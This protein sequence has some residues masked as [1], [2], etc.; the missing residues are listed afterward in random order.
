MKKALKITGWTLLSLVVVVLIVVCVAVYVVFTPER[1]TP[2]VR[3]YVPQFVTCETSLD[4]A[5]LT[6]FSTFPEFG[7]RLRNV[8]LKNPMCGAPSDTLANIDNL[9]A[10]IDV[11]QFLA[12]DA[13]VVK[14]VML[15]G[16][17]VNLY[18]DSLGRT[19]YDIVVASD[20]EQDTTATDLPFDLLDIH[21]VQIAN[22]RVL[23]TD[24]QNRMR[25]SIDD[26]QA[27]IS[28]NYAETDVM[29]DVSLQL[30]QVLFATD[31]TTRIEVQVP[32]VALRTKAALAD[33]DA[34]ASI[35]L[36]LNSVNCAIGGD[37]LLTQADI[38]AT[39]PLTA[40]LDTLS[41][42]LHEAELALAGHKI[43][44]DGWAQMRDTN[45]V[46]NVDFATDG[47]WQI[48]KVVSLIP[49]SYADL[50]DGIDVEGTIGLSGCVLGVYNSDTLPQITANVDLRNAKVVID[51]LPYKLYDVGAKAT[52]HLDLN[53]GAMSDA[54]ITQLTAKTGTC[55]VQAAGR[56]TDLL[57]AL[58]CNLHLTADVNLPE[59]SPLLPADLNVALVGRTKADVQTK[60][61]LADVLALNLDKIVAQGTL[62]FS[63]LDVVYNDSIFVE[64]PALTLNVSLPSPGKNRS[65]QEM[66]QAQITSPDLRIEMLG[67]LDAALTDATLTVATSNVLDTT[68]MLSATCEFAMQHLLAHMDTISA[69][70]VAPKG[71]ITLSPSRRNA[72][73]PRL[74]CSYSSEMLSANMGSAFNAKTKHIDISASTTY[75][76]TQENLYLKWNP[77]LKIDFNDGCFRMAGID[78]EIRI[79][80]IKFAFT[81]RK[82]TI[83]DSRIIID[84]SDFSLTGEARNIRK[85]M[86]HNGLLEGEFDFVSEQTDINQLLELVNGFGNTDS[87]QTA[88]VV[89]ADT[90]EQTV[91]QHD[92]PFMVPK[93]ID[94]SLNTHI[95]NALFADNRLQN[96]AGKLT[97]KDGVLVLEQMG[98]T[99][100]AAEMQL[101]AIYRSERR[102]HL[103]AGLDFHLI[104]IDIK[105]LIHMVPNVDTI[106]PM[107]KSFEGR[108]QFHLAAETYLKSNYELKISTLRGAA[109]I[110]GKDLVLLDSETFAKIAKPLL[111]S[112]KTKNLVDSISV[113]ATV[114]RDEVDLYPF[115]MSMD[116][117]SAVVGGRYDLANNYNAHIETLSP[118]RLALQIKGNA[119]DLDNM[120]FKL[121]KT[122][123]SDMYKP[124]KRNVLQERTLALKKLI[125]DAL[126]SNVK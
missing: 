97:V 113:E 42:R 86:K 95:K 123:Y 38:K 74:Q 26:V 50:L 109:A 31:D 8:C 32:Q 125:S 116:K 119:T 85:F 1:L 2:I 115:V 56:V 106:F 96:I 30:R 63:D 58:R 124:E 37:N 41:L 73:N 88:D 40:N 18:T 99:C 82:L 65:F 23:Y 44:L 13:L 45:I 77:T 104:N 80:A 112:R 90:V 83:D 14:A 75:D 51:G 12:D 57:G 29:A 10:T 5:D 118:I 49:P 101:T 55:A 114:F 62:K 24:N 117:Y 16:G 48:E 66:I 94:L 47:A 6:F 4:E 36:D 78:P 34:Q 28:G 108:A 92:N 19:N 7:V 105:Q 25:A 11:W 120:E 59:L 27:S 84:R 53:D 67:T 39:I 33:N 100:E 98:F 15:D 110:E 69:D 81:P 64:A 61:A 107:L 102:N 22:L 35:A 87:T 79:P 52:A 43:T 54:V 71:K 21:A 122:Q 17:Y 20:D 72:K 46:M 68:K 126:K 9:T 89:A 111:F 91:E 3:K 70:I 103:F 76:E 93:G 60:F 121:V